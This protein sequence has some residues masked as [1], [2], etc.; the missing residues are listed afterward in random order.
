M[1]SFHR[2]A[3]RSD[4][5][6]YQSATGFVPARIEAFLLYGSK[7]QLSL[8]SSFLAYGALRFFPRS[9]HSASGFQSSTARSQSSASRL[10]TTP[11]SSGSFPCWPVCSW[12]QCSAI[13][14]NAPPNPSKNPSLPIRQAPSSKSSCQFCWTLHFRPHSSSA[15]WTAALSRDT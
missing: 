2:S 12:A 3:P 11:S 4:L 13:C 9:S 8:L 1:K 15:L 6:V 5:W 10:L 7:W 14:T